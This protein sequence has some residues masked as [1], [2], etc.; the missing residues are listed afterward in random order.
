M[1][2]TEKGN[3]KRPGGDG[4]GEGKP[5]YIWGKDRV[6][7][8]GGREESEIQEEGNPFHFYFRAVSTKVTLTEW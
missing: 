6:L 8:K 4:G 2:G 3:I 5:R 7:R 1:G